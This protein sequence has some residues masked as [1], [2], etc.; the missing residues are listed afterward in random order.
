MTMTNSYKAIFIFAIFMSFVSLF[1]GAKGI[2]TLFWGYVAWLM[3][4]KN[5]VA[6]ITIFKLMSYLLGF[7]FLIGIY[8]LTNNTFNEK[9]IGY[10]AEGFFLSL[11]VS[12]IINIVLLRYF[13]NLQKLIPKFKRELRSPTLQNNKITSDEDIYLQISHELESG[14]TDKALWTK[15]FAE[16]DGNE[17]KTKASYIKQR[18][19]VIK[20]KLE[21]DLS[22][23]K[24]SNLDNTVEKN[25]EFENLQKNETPDLK[26][27]VENYWNSL[28]I[29]GK[30]CIVFIT[31]LIVMS[32]FAW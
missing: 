15:I 12:V 8:F 4:K 27:K 13:K 21:I 24:I 18:F 7:S 6:L 23:I 5:I 9:W 19:N 29:M 2:G 1:L 10:S 26:F 14:L 30:L 22:A 25:I 17:N 20:S 11:L 28:N 31:I 3:Y 32:I 16:T